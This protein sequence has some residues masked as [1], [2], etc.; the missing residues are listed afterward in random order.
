MIATNLDSWERIEEY[1][2]T[3]GNEVS[4][5]KSYCKAKLNVLKETFLQQH[6][7]RCKL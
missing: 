7:L 2:N 4:G 5:S 1:I 6:F 3:I